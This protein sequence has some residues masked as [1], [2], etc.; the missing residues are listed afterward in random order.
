MRAG[1]GR[2]V[3]KSDTCSDLTL[4]CGVKWPGVGWTGCRTQAGSADSNQFEVQGD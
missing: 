3:V 1:K 2:Q 4:R